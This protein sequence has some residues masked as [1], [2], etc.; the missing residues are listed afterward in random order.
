MFIHV[1]FFWMKPE[2]T[3]AQH[4]QLRSDAKSLLSQIPGVTLLDGGRPAMTPREVVDNS[5][6]IGLLVMFADSAAHDVYQTH[7]LHL[8]FIER[9]KANWQRVQI[10]DFN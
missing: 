6:H 10:Y 4:E 5:Y 1:V 3:P 8:Q 7:P 2:A 9:N